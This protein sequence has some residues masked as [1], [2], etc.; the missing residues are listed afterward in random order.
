[1]WVSQIFH[2]LSY[3]ADKMDTESSKRH[4]NSHSGDK[5]SRAKN[6]SAEREACN[7]TTKSH[8]KLESNHYENLDRRSKPDRKS[9][10]HDRKSG[11]HDRKSGSHDTKSGSHDRK[12][13]D[14]DRK[15]HDKDRKSSDKRSHDR[16]SKPAEA[17]RSRDSRLSTIDESNSRTQSR[18][19]EPGT[20][21][22]KTRS[23][24]SEAKTVDKKLKAG[25]FDP[26][27]SQEIPFQY[28]YRV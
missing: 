28:T 25:D 21:E 2:A 22:A 26:T 6:S 27:E 10:S 12:S 9:G 5:R 4:S 24:T 8:D 19:S 13:H 16:R 17:Y 20:L 11:E 15:S 14:P 1:M 18:S 23:G 7:S 3:I